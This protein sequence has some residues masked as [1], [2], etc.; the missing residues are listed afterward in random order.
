[1]KNSHI[2]GII[3]V[4]TGAF[5]AQPSFAAGTLRIEVNE[6]FNLMPQN[7]VVILDARP[8]SDY[9]D[10]HIPGARSLPFGR[11]FENLSQTGRVL[12]LQKAQVLFSSAGLKPDDMVVIYD[13]GLLLHAA[14]VFWTLEVYGHAN[15]RILDG[16]INA[17]KQA[18]YPM[19]DTPAG[20][21]PTH[22]VPSINPARLATRLTTLVASRKPDS[23]VILDARTE[24]HYEGLQSEASRFGHIPEARNIAVTQ[25]LSADGSRLKPIQDLAKIY[26]DVPK[27]KKII[28]YC[29]IGLASSLEYMVLRELGYNVANYDAS[30]KEW[31]NDPALPV[32]NPATQGT[33]SR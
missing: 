31:G 5:F 8:V 3:F 23:F 28:T 7:K 16:G 9:E 22:Y 18:G 19:T 17:W 1:M 20:F 10:D 6:L 25:N 21:S 13:S 24:P 2:L 11:T 15:V 12:P 30:W 32:I 27:S 33:G 14:R 29:S 26:Q 4:W